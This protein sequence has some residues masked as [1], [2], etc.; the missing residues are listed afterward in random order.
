[1]PHK[2]PDC[3]KCHRKMEHDEWLEVNERLTS[4]DPITEIWNRLVKCPRCG[5]KS[6]DWKARWKVR[7]SEGMS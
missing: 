1:M 6:M 5:T 2:N 7:K 3:P 4:I